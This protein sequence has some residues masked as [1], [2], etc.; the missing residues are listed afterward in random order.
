MNNAEVQT[1]TLLPSI[2]LAWDDSWT[3]H[4]ADKNPFP[5]IAL[6]LHSICREKII[7]DL[8]Q[9]PQQFV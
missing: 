3:W 1:K 4:P 6:L 8:D 5:Y 2:S 7:F 9:S